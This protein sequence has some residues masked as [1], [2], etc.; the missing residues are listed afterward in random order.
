MKLEVNYN[1]L[2]ICMVV[3]LILW[4]I[5]TP[6]GLRDNAWHL[7]SIFA[8]VIVG[9]LTKAAPM[10]TMGML[11]ISLSALLGVLVPNGSAHPAKDGIVNALSG[12]GNSIIWLIGV[13]FFIAEGFMKTGLGSRIA[14]FF[15]GKLGRTTLGL[16][17]GLNLSDL[18]LAPVMPSNTARVGGIVYP[19]T[20]SIAR[21][22]G[23][24]HTGPGT[25]NRTAAFLTLNAFHANLI[26]ASLFLTGTASNAMV[27][28][29]AADLG[30]QISWASWA[31]AASVPA[32]IAF[33]LMPLLLY[34]LMP[35]SVK[36]TENA[37]ELAREALRK[38]G[39]MKRE[40]WMMLIAFLL[41]LFLWVFGASLQ[42]DVT[43]A[44]LLGVCFLLLT[45]V[46]SWSDIK[47]EQAAW[48]TIV[49]FAAL[50]MMASYLAKLG[51]TA[52]VAEN[53]KA[54]IAQL[55][56]YYAFPI[57]I[58]LYYYLH[59]LFASAT[60]HVAA[61][62]FPMLSVGV[63]VGVPPLMLALFLGFCGGLMGG[64]TNYT[65]GS[66][67]IL[68]SAGYVSLRNWWKFGFVLSVL[69][70][71]IFFLFG[72]IWWKILGMW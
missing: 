45:R 7:F 29:F 15:I 48:D 68:F 1:R 56:W 38:M 6:Q 55:S 47:G 28:K 26:T 4:L 53:I 9:I 21:R 5:P 20:K 69:F 22:L 18:I 3:G 70:L 23:S 35:P 36:R 60:A 42:I 64:L 72:G 32:L 61:L 30:V 59:Y 46:L 52:W 27:Q 62:Y 31:V 12:F 57:V 50:V 51:F 54:Y 67:P 16:A 58:L 34:K 17:Y 14:Y 63:A 13:A 8:F 11:G 33:L 49:W 66:A 39:E 2:L 10:G 37:P 24:V 19:I 40:E 71:F 44:A 43:T 41:L 25:H 65:Q